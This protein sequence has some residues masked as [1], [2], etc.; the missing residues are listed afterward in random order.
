MCLI[1]FF[2]VFFLNFRIIFLSKFK[3]LME[4]AFPQETNTSEVFEYLVFNC[5]HVLGLSKFPIDG[6]PNTNLGLTS[7]PSGVSIPDFN[8]YP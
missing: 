4:K 1:I 6:N 7:T 3:H 5:D 2:Y 8:L